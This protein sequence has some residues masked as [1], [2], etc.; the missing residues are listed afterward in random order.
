MKYLEFYKESI[1]NPEKFWATQSQNLQWYKP[2]ENILSIGTNDYPQWF[3]DG[4]LNL[5]YLCIDKHIEDGFGEQNAIIY[6]SPV[7]MSK[8]ILLTINCMKKF[9]N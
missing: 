3:A 1:D 5:S 7:T 9:P 8:S 4:K 6:D 2:P